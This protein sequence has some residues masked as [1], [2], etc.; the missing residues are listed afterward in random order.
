[1][2]PDLEADP[3]GVAAPVEEPSGPEPP[4]PEED[5]DAGTPRAA[6]N[7]R[8]PAEAPGEP[9]PA[10]AAPVVAAPVVV[11]PVVVVESDG[12]GPEPG[13]A[14]GAAAGGPATRYCA[15]CGARVPLAADGLHCREGHRLS[16]AH[17]R[18]RFGL[19]RRR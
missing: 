6:P 7:E 11:A 3:G 14:G 2:S 4:P 9:V 5:E 15:T 16:P 12:P 18:R 1:V 19:S 10:L 17:A 8:A 13:A